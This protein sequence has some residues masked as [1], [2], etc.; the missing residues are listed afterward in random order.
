MAKKESNRK[1]FLAISILGILLLPALVLRVH[2]GNRYTK[3]NVLSS[4]LTKTV[5][6]PS[7]T[8][9]TFA[10]PEVISY[11]ENNGSTVFSFENEDD[12]S[13]G[14]TALKLTFE[15]SDDPSND[16][17]DLKSSSQSNFNT[18]TPN[19]F[20]VKTHKTASSTVTNFLHNY[21]A[22]HFLRIVKL[23][24]SSGKMWTIN[25]S[26][27]LHRINPVPCNVWA[28]HIELPTS[29]FSLPSHPTFL[30]D[31]VPNA[32]LV[33]ILRHPVSR[34]LSVMNYYYP[35]QSAK[36]KC[37]V[38][39]M[40][41]D[42]RRRVAQRY[43]Q[44]AAVGLTQDSTDEE[45]KKRIDAFEAVLITEF[46]HESLLL[47]REKLR[48]KPIDIVTFDMKTESSHVCNFNI[49]ESERDQVLAA[50]PC[51]AK[52]YDYAVKRFNKEK[53]EVFSD[54]STFSKTLQEQA[55]YN[56][57][58]REACK[59]FLEN[60]SPESVP[61]VL[62]ELGPRYKEFCISSQYDNVGWLKK[63]QN[64]YSTL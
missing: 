58:I 46:L 13:N 11:H 49:S 33:T 2:W 41:K 17:T 7:G 51:D 27:K 3:N 61:R 24:Y 30:S 59:E 22:L 47:M 10:R 36:A 25:D 50:L 20:F 56:V 19:I 52:L 32:K 43:T 63:L 48:L 8:I 12:H 6:L 14:I 39:N 5:Q 4:P 54:S 45:I 62:L 55:T 15:N 60:P 18:N 29:D 23:G 42:S 44:C 16:T 21:V 9:S 57:A 37:K 53:R 35:H 64:Q 28:N 26:S 31:L 38:G 1:Q 34:T 40:L